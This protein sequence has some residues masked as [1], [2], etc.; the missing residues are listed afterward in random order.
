MN[1]ELKAQLSARRPLKHIDKAATIYELYWQEG[2]SI[3]AIA[4]ELDVNPSTIYEHMK[5]YGIPRRTLLEA[6]QK[7]RRRR[8]GGGRMKARGG[9]VKVLCPDHP[10]A[11]KRGYIMEH[12]LVM[13]KKLGRYLMP[14]EIVHH[15]E[16]VPKDDNRPENLELVSP[17]ENLALEKL[18]RNCPLKKEIRLVRWQIKE[19]QKQLQG[20]LIDK[21]GSVE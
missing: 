16:G 18:C 1:K 19:L 7:I 12:R 11:D 15:K 6:R 21:I 2:K 9:Y 4:K 17:L 13:E 3:R 14:W 8:W 5:H 10:F 20:R